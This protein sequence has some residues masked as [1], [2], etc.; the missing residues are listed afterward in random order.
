MMW[1]VVTFVLCTI[2]AAAHPI[3]LEAR[4]ASTTVVRG[5]EVYEI[6]RSSNDAY[7]RCAPGANHW[8]L[9]RRDAITG[10]LPPPVSRLLR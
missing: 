9:H 3:E 2:L 4:Q 1:A 6:G 10:I 8:T 7:P 5:L